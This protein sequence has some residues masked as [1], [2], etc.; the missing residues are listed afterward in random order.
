LV[1]T[2]YCIR[3]QGCNVIFF[4]INKVC[5]RFRLHNNFLNPKISLNPLGIW[6]LELGIWGLSLP[7]Y[8]L[9]LIPQYSLVAG[10]WIGK[11]FKLPLWNLGF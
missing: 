1:E 6:N 7:R 3:N 5:L 2:H 4:W 8:S 10:G 9:T 11:Y